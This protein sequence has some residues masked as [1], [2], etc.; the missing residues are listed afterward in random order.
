MDNMS[1]EII[2][3]LEEQKEEMKR[4]AERTERR[5]KEVEAGMRGKIMEGEKEVREM[6]EGTK[7]LVC[8]YVYY[9]CG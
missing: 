3:Y 1:K 4:M 7:D 2:I 5:A 8:S 6:V 9:I